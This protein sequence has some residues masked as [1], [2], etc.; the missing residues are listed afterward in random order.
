MWNITFWQICCLRLRYH[1]QPL[2]NKT[3]RSRVKNMCP[4]H[5]QSL[6]LGNTL[7]SHWHGLNDIVRTDVAGDHEV[8]VKTVIKAGGSQSPINHINLEHF[9]HVT[10]LP[11][12]KLNLLPVGSDHENDGQ[13]HHGGGHYGPHQ[14]RKHQRHLEINIQFSLNDPWMTD[15]IVSILFVKS[16]IHFTWNV[17]SFN[18]GLHYWNKT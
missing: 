5:I 12:L 16:L 3:T 6:N 7:A 18:V 4:D 14:Q 2:T 8:H 9:S 13:H 15:G 10:C 17:K 11:L 1:S